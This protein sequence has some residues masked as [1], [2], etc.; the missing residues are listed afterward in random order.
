M[1][2][3]PS[4]ISYYIINLIASPNRGGS[5][6]SFTST[7]QASQGRWLRV[8][9]TTGDDPV[10]NRKLSCLYTIMRIQYLLPICMEQELK[11]ADVHCYSD[12]IL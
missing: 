6:S 4:K 1:K 8:A 11:L 7:S 10:P 9:T 5:T 2:I 12:I 3:E